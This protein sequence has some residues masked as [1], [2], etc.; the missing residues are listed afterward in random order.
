MSDYRDTLL[1]SLER[2]PLILKRLLADAPAKRI[3]WSPRAGI[4][5]IREHIHHLSVTQIMLAK[6][7]RLFFDSARPAIVPFIPDGDGAPDA[8]SREMDE[9]IQVYERFRKR[10][11]ETIQGANESVWQI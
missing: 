4:W 7:L 9:L 5:T 1:L 6:R 10:Q 8:S 3:D 2:N 11:I